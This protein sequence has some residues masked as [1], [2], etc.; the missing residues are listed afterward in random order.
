MNICKKTHSSKKH[1]TLWLFF[2]RIFKVAKPKTL[3]QYIYLFLYLLF[4]NLYNILLIIFSLLNSRPN[5]S[6]SAKIVA[7]QSATELPKPLLMGICLSIFISIIILAP[8]TTLV[9]GNTKIEMSVFAYLVYACL[10]DEGGG[11]I[12]DS[13]EDQ[14]YNIF[15]FLPIYQVLE[16]R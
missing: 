15:L 3:A 13:F 9:I 4:L 14:F 7:I 10:K 11:R 1:K 8:E 5:R 12:F 2:F 6:L 16:V